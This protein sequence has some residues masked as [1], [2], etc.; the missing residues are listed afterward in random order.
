MLSV[1]Q[2]GEAASLAAPT[3]VQFVAIIAVLSIL[4]A[5]VMTRLLS[6][7]LHQHSEAPKGTTM[8][9][10]FCRY[11]TCQRCSVSATFRCVYG[12]TAMQQQA[13]VH[14]SRI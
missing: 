2:G 11:R 4:L 7:N 8:C 14:Q 12:C 5:W 13:V 9:Q 6:P 10:Q 1:S 3:T